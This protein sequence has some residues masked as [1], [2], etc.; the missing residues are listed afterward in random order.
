MRNRTHLLLLLL[1]SIGAVA[2]SAATGHDELPDDASS[3]PVD[4]PTDGAFMIDALPALDSAPGCDAKTNVGCACHGG[5]SQPCYPGNPADRGRGACAAGTQ[6]CGGAGELGTWGEC[7][8]A[9]LPTPEI[10]GNGIDDDCNGE[11]DEGCVI[12]VPVDIHGDCVTVSCPAIAPYPVGCDIKMS[13]GNPHG[14]VA[15]APGSSTVF[16]EEGVVCDAGYLNGTLKCSSAPGGVIDA[17]TCVIN[18]P[19]PTYVTNR[20]SCPT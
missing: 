16:F 5:A 8:G 7:E 3:D 18:K 13:G 12:D 4:A 2:C 1:I 14:C 17:K 15:W 19:K 6:F 10:C 9:V 20:K 11:V